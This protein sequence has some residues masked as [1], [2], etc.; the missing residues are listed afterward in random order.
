M[1]SYD[2]HSKYT[3]D[4]NTMIRQTFVHFSI[5]D[6]RT[7]SSLQETGVVEKGQMILSQRSNQSSVFGKRFGHMGI[8]VTKSLEHRDLSMSDMMVKISGCTRKLNSH[9]DQSNVNLKL[10]CRL[11]TS[12]ENC[13]WR[14]ST[15]VQSHFLSDIETCSSISLTIKSKSSILIHVRQAFIDW[16]IL[17]IKS[18]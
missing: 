13:I 3:N 18:E 1:I 15:I 7:H 5:N 6:N 14:Y 12:S 17:S 10:D 4:H 16:R 9:N 8:W 11:G 2:N